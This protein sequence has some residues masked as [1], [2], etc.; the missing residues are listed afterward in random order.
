MVEGAALWEAW[1]VAYVVV[2]EYHLLMFLLEW[3][4]KLRVLYVSIGSWASEVVDVEA[5]VA[6][7]SLNSACEL[8][9]IPVDT[10]LFSIVFRV[11]IEDVVLHNWIIDS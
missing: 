7:V 5:S 10:A 3:Q 6:L 11:E 2:L 8:D 1:I 4:R 9:F